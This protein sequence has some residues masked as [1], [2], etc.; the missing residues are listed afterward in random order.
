MYKSRFGERK[1]PTRDPYS[2][3]QR[4]EGGDRR[5]NLGCIN[6]MDTSGVYGIYHCTFQGTAC[7]YF[8]LK[9][10][11]HRLDA[12]GSESEKQKLTSVCIKNQSGDQL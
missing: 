1:R 10:I 9:A 2:M 7:E 6:K 12:N 8:H 5:E 11:C 3:T 4:M